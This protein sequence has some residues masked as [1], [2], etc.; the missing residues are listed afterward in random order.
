MFHMENAGYAA[1]S[2]SL[3]TLAGLSSAL[4]A[5][6]FLAIVGGPTAGSTL[7]PLIYKGLLLGVFLAFYFSLRDGAKSVWRGIAFVLTCTAADLA[8]QLTAFS[9][10]SVFPMQGSAHLEISYPVLF[11]AGFVG[12][13]LIIGGALLLFRTATIRWASF[14]ITLLG[15]AG[16]G[17]LGIIGWNLGK[18]FESLLSLSLGA[19]FIAL[20]V[21]WQTG[22]AVVLG[23]IVHYERTLVVYPN[24]ELSV[25][26]FLVQSKKNPTVIAALF[27]CGVFGFFGWNIFRIEQMDEMR[28]KRQENQRQTLKKSYDEAPSVANLPPLQRREVSRVLLLQDLAGLHADNPIVSE[29]PSVPSHGEFAPHPPAISYYVAYRQK[30]LRISSDPP[31]VVIGAAPQFSS[32]PSITAGV[33]QYPNSEWALYR[34]KYSF[35]PAMDDRRSLVSVVKFGKR[36][37]KDGRLCSPGGGGEL[38]YFWPSGDVVVTISYETR[39]VKEEFIEGFIERYLERYPSSIPNTDVYWSVQR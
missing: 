16:G 30:N 39:D 17:L 2:L 24:G 22:L 20:E 27:F 31:I 7:P 3:I 18:L 26:P 14:G 11:A 21:V 34:T 23:F 32:L 38:K 4:L 19:E 35:N 10:E 1:K 29:I 6:P 15:A 33:N 5:I 13:F 28:A 12:A 37:I 25:T 9:L 8:S 36:I